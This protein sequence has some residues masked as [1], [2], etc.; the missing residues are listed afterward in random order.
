[1]GNRNAGGR[2]RSRGRLST[3]KVRGGNRVGLGVQRRGRDFQKSNSWSC[4][5]GQLKKKRV[6]PGKVTFYEEGD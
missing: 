4:Q 3:G 2:Y 1:V 5:G 6:V